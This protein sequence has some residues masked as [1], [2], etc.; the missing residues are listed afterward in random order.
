M[1]MQEQQ[2]T[3]ARQQL[4]AV[5]QQLATMGGQ[6]AATQ[7]NISATPPEVM[8]EGDSANPRL[9]I[10]AGH[11]AE[12]S[13]VHLPALANTQEPLMTKVGRHW[14]NLMTGI[15]RLVDQ[16]LVAVHEVTPEELDFR[17]QGFVSARGY[18]LMD[19]WAQIKRLPQLLS[20]LHRALLIGLLAPFPSQWFDTKGSTGVMRTLAGIEMLCLYV[21]LPGILLASW[22]T[23]RRGDPAGLFLLTF[24]VLLACVLSLVVANLG[25]LF[26]LR[27]Q[28]L[29]PLVMLAPIG[30]PMTAYR[31]LYSACRSLLVKPR[32]QPRAGA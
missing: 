14:E 30:H 21:L 7:E 19:S 6:L 23:V 11:V 29:L 26:R 16:A 22:N 20:Y 31:R 5:E 17:R 24:I 4:H 3:A 28:F 25:T 13:P 1:A 2:L 9:G 32:I 18:S 15:G 12:P 10:L 8:A 27:L